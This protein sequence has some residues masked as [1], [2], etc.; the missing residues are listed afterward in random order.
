MKK[1]FLLAS[2]A[3]MMLAGCSSDDLVNDNNLGNGIGSQI[4]STRNFL[5]VTV[6]PTNGMGTRAGDDDDTATTEAPG[7][8]QGGTE[9]ESK[10]Q[11]IRFFFF[12]NDGNATPVWENRS[13]GSYNSFIDWYPNNEDIDKVGND[14]EHTETVLHTTLGLVI[15]ESHSKPT[16]VI[17]VVNPTSAIRNLTET[18]A[19]V[20]ETDITLVGPSKETLLSEVADYL[21]G[22]TGGK[23]ED[24][25][26]MSNS[27]Y[28]KNGEVV[29]A[30]KL[31]DESFTTTPPEDRENYDNIVTI[32]VERVLARLDFGISSEMTNAGT[33]ESPIYSVNRSYKVGDNEEEIYVK[34]LGWNV[35]GTA[36]Q[37]RLVK[38]V[39]P[40]WTNDDLFKKG[41]NEPWN[42][43][44]Y[45]RSFWA[46]N[47]EN[48]EYQYGDFGDFNGITNNVAKAAE[49]G[50]EN[51]TSLSN[52]NPA[53]LKI[54]KAGDYTT[55]YLQENANDNTD[56]NINAVAPKY[57]TKVIIAAQLCHEDGTH[58]ELAEWNYHKYTKEGLLKEFA[59]NE[60]GQLYFETKGENNT[61]YNQI[62]PEDLTFKTAAQ[63]RTEYKDD[64]F[65]EGDAD[66]YVYVV[67]SDAAKKKSW[68]LNPDKTNAAN[69]TPYTTAQVT[70]YIYDC[71]NHVR[72]WNNG[73][74]YYFF[75]VQHLGADDTPGQYGIVRNH[76]YKTTVKS[77]T[78]LGTPVYDPDQIIIPEQ[79]EYDESIVTADV[80]ILQW[81]VVE[82]GYELNWK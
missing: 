42:T 64:S 33:D 37:S 21:T 17:A 35:T 30:T 73:M 32:H 47:P 56:G 43:S 76:I 38:S 28:V 12:D 26:V 45:Y 16:S 80:K 70:A 6:L 58:Y 41:T 10:V 24:S 46:L 14:K 25:F 11:S 50:N 39:N 74:T 52:V 7:E 59:N 18:D 44:D 75:D 22:L 82:S 15:P 69:N 48:V 20:A 49:E 51:S 29:D 5:T 23:D 2:L 68:Y 78:G 81:R 53:M 63:L 4:E 65:A 77:V 40:T 55:T 71:I 61:T 27:V 13:T 60:L 54:E 57:A 72:V 8:Y 36:D 66:F 34:F 9:A 19:K 3:G 67:L 62:T 79:N 31:T 1:M